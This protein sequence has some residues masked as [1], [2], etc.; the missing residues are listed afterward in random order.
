[1]TV[2]E[3]AATGFGTAASTYAASRPSYPPDAVAWIVHE[4]R[5]RAGTRCV[6]LAAGT[7]I[8]TRLLAPTMCTL[9]A[10]EPVDAM[11]DELQRASPGASMVAAVGEA[12]PFASR[13]LH[14]ITIAQAF[15]W[16]DA[17]PALD[18]IHRC[19]Q[20]GG[21]I[22]MLWNARLR[23]VDWVD[24]VWAVMDRVEKHAPWRNHDHVATTD[25][26]AFREDELL[27]QP[28]FD[29]LRTA[30][31]E[32]LQITDHDGVVARVASVSHVAVLPTSEKTEVL[33]EVRE[34]LARHPDTAGRDS[35]AI[36]YRV[37]CYAITRATTARR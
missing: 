2:H 11:R 1:M 34:I 25:S 6:D 23:N 16:F 14:A 17:D 15:H 20:P 7:G 32:H 29:N 36:P 27:R 21:S 22:A 4:L 31:F 8:F 3:V 5:L 26:K 18:E 30:Q 10:A 9:I 19:V 37:D 28:G 13:S 24:Q 12:L 35:L 33:N